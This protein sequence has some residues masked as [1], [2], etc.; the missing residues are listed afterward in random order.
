MNRIKE[1]VAKINYARER[2]RLRKIDLENPEKFLAENVEICKKIT[3]NY[4]YHRI[5]KENHSG[6]AAIERWMFNTKRFTFKE[7]EIDKPV[8]LSTRGLPIIFSV[9]DQLRI[10]NAIKYFEQHEFDQNKANTYNYY[11][12]PLGIVITLQGNHSQYVANCCTKLDQIEIRDVIDISEALKHDFLHNF[13]NFNGFPQ[14]ISRKYL[15]KLLNN[16]YYLLKSDHQKIFPPE[17][18][19][20]IDEEKN[21]LEHTLSTLGD[22]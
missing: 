6:C 20:A 10:R 18:L 15:H 2:K 17:I 13:K 16:G 5:L 22:I 19:K 11:V 14:K 1:L 4:Y 8:F 9:W 3:D 12:F 7:V 21:V